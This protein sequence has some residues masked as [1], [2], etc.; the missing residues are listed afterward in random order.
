[1]ELIPSKHHGECSAHVMLSI[2]GLKAEIVHSK[3]GESLPS[4]YFHLIQL[5]FTTHFPPERSSPLKCALKTW[6]R[7]PISTQSP[8]LWSL[9]VWDSPDALCTLQDLWCCTEGACLISCICLERCAFFPSLPSRILCV[10]WDIWP[11]M[12]TALS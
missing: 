7:Y 11:H 8:R 9:Q 6:F 4:T 3:E 12:P 10:F 1:M 2:Y 5:S